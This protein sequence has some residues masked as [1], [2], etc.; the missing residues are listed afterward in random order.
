RA[1]LQGA[2]HRYGRFIPLPGGG[3]QN[4]HQMKGMGVAC[5]LGKYLRAD[6]LRLGCAARSVML[7]RNPYGLIESHSPTVVPFA[8]WK[9][10]KSGPFRLGKGPRRCGC[11][12]IADLCERIEQVIERAEPAEGHHVV[13]DDAEVWRPERND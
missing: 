6:S 2:A 11:N 3:G 1:V 7:V 12:A 9:A 4:P 8:Y 13:M 5:L 10:R